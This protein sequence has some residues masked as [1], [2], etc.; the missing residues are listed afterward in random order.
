MTRVVEG[1]VKIPDV[2]RG[3]YEDLLKR[4]YKEREQAL[5]A[6]AAADPTVDLRVVAAL[7]VAKRLAPEAAG[8]VSRSALPA[9]WNQLIDDFARGRTVHSVHIVSDEEW[10]VHFEVHVNE[11]LLHGQAHFRR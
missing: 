9:E 10:G 6:A 11:H 7:A 3:P 2:H 5:L 4:L 8:P 1:V